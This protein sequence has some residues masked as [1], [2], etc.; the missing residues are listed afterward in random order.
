MVSPTSTERS[1]RPPTRA[2]VSSRW[3]G[4]GF[5]TGSVSAPSKAAKWRVE[6]ELLDQDQRQPLGLVRADAELPAL[7]REAL[8]RRLGAL[9]GPG[10]DGDGGGVEVE[11]PRVEAVDEARLG[12]PRPQQALAQ[13]RPAAGEG[14]GPVGDRVEQ[15]GMAELGQGRVRRGDEVG[16]GVGEGAVEVE[17]CHAHGGAFCPIAAGY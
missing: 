13:H 14:D 3:R 16:G 4:S 17:D 11:E 15:A 2:M 7:R 12:D 8:E 6:S 9:V 1:G 10:V 5:F